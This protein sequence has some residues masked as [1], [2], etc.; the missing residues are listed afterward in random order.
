MYS[1]VPLPKLPTASELADLLVTW[2]S[3]YYAIP[4]D[5]LWVTDLKSYHECGEPSAQAE[6][7]PEPVLYPV[8]E[9]PNRG[10]GGI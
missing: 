7:Y 2:A 8:T 1:L 6:Y 3:H 4:E 9:W 5:I 10:G